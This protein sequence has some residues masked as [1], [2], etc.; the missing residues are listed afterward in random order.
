MSSREPAVDVMR[1]PYTATVPRGA[2]A[3]Q[4]TF[5][6]E[7]V[8]NIPKVQDDPAMSP[9]HGGRESAF[10]P[11]EASASTPTSMQITPRERRPRLSLR[12][13]TADVPEYGTAWA[14]G[15]ERLRNSGH[16]FVETPVFPSATGW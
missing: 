13:S 1:V 2:R 5:P 4:K 3:R 6:H 9:K 7:R 15:E 11:T 14:K 16:R 8:P 10:L 12:L